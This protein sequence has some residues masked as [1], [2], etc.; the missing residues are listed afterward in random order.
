M[1]SVVAIAVCALLGAAAPVRADETFLLGVEA[2][3]AVPLVAPQSERVGAGGMLA[4]SGHYATLGWL[5]PG[6]RVRAGVLADVAPAP[7]AIDEGI[8][9]FGSVMAILRFRPRSIFFPEEVP[10]ATCVWLEIGAGAALAQGEGRPSFE[11]GVGFTFE[12]GPIGL[13]PNVRVL[14]TMPVTGNRGDDLLITFGAELVLFD[15]R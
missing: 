15:A 3:A 11:V 13:G 7:G 1:R 9:T 8:G 14:H 10:R 2:A 4:V 6:V 5:I 12:L